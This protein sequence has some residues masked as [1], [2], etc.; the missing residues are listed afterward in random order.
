[1]YVVCLAFN[2]ENEVMFP[3]V[4]VYCIFS[5]NQLIVNIIIIIFLFPLSLSLS[6]IF[7]LNLPSSLSPSLP[8][9]SPSPSL[10]LPLSLSL[11]PS[12]SLQTR[13]CPLP[14]HTTRAYQG[15]SDAPPLQSHHNR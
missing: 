13:L 1:M 2:I 7:S 12:P 4:L 8:S 14:G 3:R 15:H 5:S 11:S 10:P 6:H 9:L